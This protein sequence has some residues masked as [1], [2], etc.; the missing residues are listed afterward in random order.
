MSALQW[1]QRLQLHPRSEN[2]HQKNLVKGADLYR[3]RQR[4]RRA[5]NLETARAYY[6]ERYAIR[7]GKY[8]C[9]RISRKRN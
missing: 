1:N 6:R 2:P 8:A 9:K 5:A 3:A 7:M 4:W